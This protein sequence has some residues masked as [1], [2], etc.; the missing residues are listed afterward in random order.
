MWM[1]KAKAAKLPCK[2]NVRTGTHC[3]TVS[4]CEPIRLFPRDF[5]HFLCF[6]QDEPVTFKKKLEN[7]TVEEQSEVKM[8]VE[9]SKAS[10]EV[11]WMKNSVV[12]QPA[13]NMEIR[14]EGAKQALVFKSVTYADRGIYSCETLDDKTQAKLSVESKTFKCI[15]CIF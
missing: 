15:M 7:L 2:C 13:G 10:E 9:L 1:Q 4:V 12:L 5:K 14:V 3:S 8:Q 11:R 6:F